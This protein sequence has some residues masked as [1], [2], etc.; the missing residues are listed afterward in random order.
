MQHKKH[1]NIRS[2]KRVT[3]CI[4]QGLHLTRQNLQNLCG[5]KIAE[6]I[7]VNEQRQ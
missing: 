7:N 2:L 5:V 6:A 3:F 1:K 4:S